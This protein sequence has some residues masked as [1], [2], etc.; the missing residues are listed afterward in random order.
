MGLLSWE[1]RHQEQGKAVPKAGSLGV[2]VPPVPLTHGDGVAVQVSSVF[3]TASAA[4]LRQA[5]FLVSC[6]RPS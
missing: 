3:G 4:V 5:E 2:D 1:E 6:R